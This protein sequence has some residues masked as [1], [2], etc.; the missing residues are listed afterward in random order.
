[1]KDAKYMYLEEDQQPAAFYP[2]AQHVPIFLNSFVV[3]YSGEPGAAIAAIRKAVAEIDPDLPVSDAQ[4]LVE[5]IDDAVL[6]R[7]LIAQLSAFFGALAAFLAC[8]G[9]YGVMSYGV[10]R[11]TNEFGIRMA[12]GAHRGQVLW[13]VLREA[14]WLGLGGL[15]IGLALALAFGRLV[16]SLLF[17]LKPYD[18]LAI[19]GAMV[20]MTLVALF[21]G[22]LPASRA[23]GID[24]MVALR[25][26]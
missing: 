26:E 12:L 17:G 5:H 24:P 19:G 7:R 22:Y 8:I 16:T 9:I 2:H 21:A 14:L 25:H 3:R 20:A 15:V 13:T 6:N 11:R 18:P 1:M 23:T 10:A 4:T